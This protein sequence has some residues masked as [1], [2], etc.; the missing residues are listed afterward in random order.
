MRY[1]LN[2]T[3]FKGKSVS[4]GKRIDNIN[5]GKVFVELGTAEIKHT[6]TPLVQEAITKALGKVN[7]KVTRVSRATAELGLLNFYFFDCDLLDPNEPIDAHR[8]YQIAAPTT[9]SGS[10]INIKMHQEFLKAHG[11]C[12]KCQR[13]KNATYNYCICTGEGSS[14]GVNKRK[15]GEPNKT[16]KALKKYAHMGA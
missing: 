8:L 5:K 2:Y 7:L 14:A 13:S 1:K 10:T 3:E 12:E 4:D 6:G 15:Y 16:K 11:L 9:T